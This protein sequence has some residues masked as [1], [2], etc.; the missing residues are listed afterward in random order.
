[1]ALPRG[2]SAARGTAMTVLC[3]AADARCCTRAPAVLTQATAYIRAARRVAAR[4][5]ILKTRCRC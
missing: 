3:L 5:S 1:M 4:A 2:A